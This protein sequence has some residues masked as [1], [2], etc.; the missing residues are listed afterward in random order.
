MELSLIILCETL[1]SEAT[2]GFQCLR[3]LPKSTP[4]TYKL[5]SRIF[6]IMFVNN[7][8]IVETVAKQWLK[9]N[10]SKLSGFKN[11]TW[12][13]RG[14]TLSKHHLGGLTRSLECTW[15]ETLLLKKRHSFPLKIKPVRLKEARYSFIVLPAFFFFHSLNETNKISPF[16]FQFPSVSL[17]QHLSQMWNT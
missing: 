17:S 1:C 12:S 2:K 11:N 9:L 10:N 13:W 15:T 5:N 4:A 7:L 6:I 14:W 3:F 8:L 16:L